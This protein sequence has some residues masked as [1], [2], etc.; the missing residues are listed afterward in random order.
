MIDK[1]YREQLEIKKAYVNQQLKGYCSVDGVIGMAEPYYY[2]NKVHVVLSREKAR[3]GKKG[4]IAA[5]IYEEESHRVVAVK[6]CLLHDRYADEI[7]ESIV[8]IMEKGRFEPYDEDRGTG[9][10]R[11]ILIRRGHVSKETMVII[12]T[13][14]KVFPGNKNFTRELLKRHPDI[15]TIVHNINDKKT[16]MVLGQNQRVLYGKG[17][18]HDILCGLKFCISPKSFYQINSAQTEILYGKA[19]EFAGLTGKEAV[20]DAYCGIGTISMV[21]SRYA[22]TVTGVELNSDAVRDAKINAR[23]NNVENV[24]FYNDDAGAFMEK[25]NE[26][27][28]VVFIDPP[29]SGSTDKFLS[30]LIRLSPKKIVYVS[31]NP[32]TQR[33]DLKRLIHGG[34]K[35][36]KACAVDMFPGTGSVETVVLLSQQK[37]DDVIE[38]EIELD[39]L[40]LT[41]AE[42]KATY[43][44]IKDYVLKEHGLKVSSLYISQVKR[45]CGIEVGEN[46]NLPKSEDS[47]QPQCP[48]E[49]EKAIGDALEHFGMV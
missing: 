41:S 22:G 40:D 30:S 48:E 42:S 47:R 16:S 3:G 31:C 1:P 12:V 37:P 11:H 15:T 13:G 18:I 21:A 43:A 28:D 45:K 34:Y 20:I 39:E 44:E 2:R 6:N 35:A 46:Y 9:N 49:K 33:R 19:M 8:D 38:V 4:K 27:P 25:I 32:E 10:I 36:E 14:T 5:G 26:K 17:Y 7:I 23:L 24:K 29:R